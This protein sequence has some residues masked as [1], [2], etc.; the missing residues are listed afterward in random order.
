MSCTLRTMY[1]NTSNAPLKK[2]KIGALTLKKTS[3]SHRPWELDIIETI[4]ISD[5]FGSSLYIHL[6]DL[7]II[8]VL[9]KRNKYLNQNWITNKSR[10]Y[11][12]KLIL[13]KNRVFFKI[14]KKDTILLDTSVNLETLFLVQQYKYIQ[15]HNVCIHLYTICNY[16]KNISLWGYK[17]FISDFK[18]INNFI[19]FGI[20]GEAEIPLILSIIRHITINKNIKIQ[21]LTQTNFNKIKNIKVYTYFI[22]IQYLLNFCAF[23][24]NQISIFKYTLF[25]YNFNLT[26][27]INNIESLLKNIVYF[28]PNFKEFYVE[29]TSNSTSFS[30]FNSF[31]INKKVNTKFVII[32]KLISKA[33]TFISTE[34][35]PQEFSY[36]IKSKNYFKLF[37]NLK[38]IFYKPFSK[39]KI[40]IRKNEIEYFLK[41]LKSEFF[42][43]IRKQPIVL[44]FSSFFWYL[45]KIKIH[46]TFIT[47]N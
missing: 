42:Y 4:D 6:S 43:Y 25:L 46:A 31:K 9:P 10:T 40:P 18:N 13:K 7:K 41:E 26:T 21:S 1:K 36:P 24:K 33:G 15:A 35:K 38:R 12:N 23:K 16:K 11:I 44:L 37:L 30:L 29:P 34:N 8:K 39:K 32:P 45:I 27:K 19:F 17:E 14:K 28:K 20:K 5:S 22:N 3:F 2:K 47:N